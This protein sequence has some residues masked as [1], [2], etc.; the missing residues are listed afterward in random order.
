MLFML[1]T[2]TFMIASYLIGSLCSA[3]LVS[4]LFALP[5]PRTEG[6]K[7]P[8]ATNVLRL[9]GKKYAFIVLLA[10]M[11]KGFLPVF[12][13]KILGYPPNVLGFACFA[14]VIGHMFP[15]F[16]NFQGGKGVATALGGI[17]G[18][19]FIFGIVVMATWLI[20]ANIT[21]YA[22][23]ASISALL[24]A[25][26]FVLFTPHGLKAFIP[27]LFTA[28]FVVYKHR[29]NITRLIDG[30]ERKIQLSKSS[31][32][33]EMEATLV[34]QEKEEEEKQF[35]DREQVIVQENQVQ[36]EAIKQK[37][38]SVKVKEN[39]AEQIAG[40]EPIIQ[41]EEKEQPRK[42]QN[43]IE[44]TTDVEWL[45]KNT[46]ESKKKI[47]KNPPKNPKPKRS[48]PSSE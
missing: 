33:A 41:I 47:L 31:L 19:N 2:L 14:A 35:E 44:P 17:L 20:I 45:P 37:G 34:E 18:I 40:I 32:A 27:L 16:F 6:S 23:L 29:E 28:C 36:K 12:M 13:L 21:R 1:L 39:S 11:L 9:S 22:S 4:Q 10:D 30:D 5:D 15:F 8:G 38:G 43:I 7:N 26:L 42:R 46:V 24:L 48:K 25:P 3:V